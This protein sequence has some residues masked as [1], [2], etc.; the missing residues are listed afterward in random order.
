M[1]PQAPAPWDMEK[2]RDG[3]AI[4]DADGWFVCY[5]SSERNAR[6][7]A[8]LAGAVA[9]AGGGTSGWRFAP[10]DTATLGSRHSQSKGTGGSHDAR[11]GGTCAKSQDPKIN[12]GFLMPRRLRF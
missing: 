9:G 5:V 3:W 7:M 11:I 4:R 1:M 10:L 12:R 2:E 8:D 6:M